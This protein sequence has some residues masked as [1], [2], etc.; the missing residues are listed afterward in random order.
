MEISPKKPPL[1]EFALKNESVEPAAVSF[2]SVP[3]PEKAPPRV[4]AALDEYSNTAP[5]AT[6][7]EVAE[8]TLPEPPICKVPALTV[9]APVKVLVPV[10]A[11]VPVPVSLTR[12]PAPDT[13]PEK[14]CAALDEY[15]N[16][17]PLAMLMALA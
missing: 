8:P 14:V 15:C 10:S 2:N 4:C 16:V 17:E 5:L 12:L 7:T 6:L 1:V 9:A 13:T 11:K 3:E